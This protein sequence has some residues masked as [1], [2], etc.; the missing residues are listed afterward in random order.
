MCAFNVVTVVLAAVI[1]HLDLMISLV[2][3]VSS[4]ALALI[5]P[6]VLELVTFWPDQLGCCRWILI[7]DICLCAF[8]V[9]GFLGGTGV[10]L[11]EI[12]KTFQGP[13]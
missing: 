2:G 9:I 6:P 10:S 7:K 8:G 12:I 5:F 11:Y 3:A 13:G 1:P 4:S